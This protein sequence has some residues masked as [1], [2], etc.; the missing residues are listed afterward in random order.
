MTLL[1]DMG[2]LA[3]PLVTFVLSETLASTNLAVIVAAMEQQG[4]TVFTYPL[5]AQLIRPRQLPGAFQFGI[6]GPPGV[7]A[8]VG[9][10]DLAA[11]SGM[12]FAT[13]QLGAIVFTDVTA[14]LSSRK[15]YR[16][17]LQSPPANMVFI[18]PNTFTMG[19]PANEQ[20]RNAFTE[21]PQT[22]VTLT[23][24]YWIGKYEVTQ[25]DYLSVMDTNPSEFPGDLTRPVS[26]VDWFDA[27][28]Y[29]WKLTQR[30][31]AAGHIPAG[32]HYRLPTEAEWE[33]AA[34]AGTT[35]RF[36][37]G[38]DP[39]YASLTNYAWFLDISAPDLT[40]HSV[41]SK[42]PNPW[43]LCDMSGNVWEWCQDWYGDQTGGIQ[44][45]PT[46]PAANPNGNKVMRG[47]AY[48]YSNSSCRSATRLFAFQFHADTDLGFRVVL[49]SEP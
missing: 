5:T 14:H 40:V 43:G 13:N 27:T 47:G 45:D 23:H 39:T 8:V 48:D 17:F 29:C 30:E 16:T 36:T 11:W 31:L 9:S 7:Y 10:P 12:G 20:D 44:T 46:G 6:T 22:T 24:G 49:V 1:T 25:G 32:S 3:N 21:G 18:P 19:S 35:T 33:C 2:F 4:V 42:L 34:R 41:G 15:F 28:N 38:D 37:Y 26:S